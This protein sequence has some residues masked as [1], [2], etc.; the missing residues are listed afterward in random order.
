[1]PFDA[2]SLL[3]AVREVNQ[4]VAGGR[5]DKIY[6]PE[7]DEVVLSIRLMR[8]GVKLLLSVGAGTPRM[9]FIE[10]GRENPA[11]PPM[12][13]M[14]LR[15]HLTGARIVS[16]SQP[17]HERMLELEIDTHDE[18]GF[19]ARK[20]LVLE[21][22]GR[23][24]NLILVGS[25]G[26]IIDCMRRMDFA[27]DAERSM[28]PGMFYRMPPKQNKL[29]VFDAAEDERRALIAQADRTAPMDKWLL[30]AFSGLSPLL[31]RELAYRCGGDHE[32]LDSCISALLESLANGETAPYMLTRGGAPFD[33]SCIAIGQYGS[34]AETERFGSFSELLDNFY[35]RRDRL[36]RQRRRGSELTH[37][38]KTLRDRTARKLA[39]QSE[40][41]SRADSREELKKQAELVTANIYRMKKGDRELRCEDYY[42]PDC[43]EIVIP[44]DV[45]KTPQQNAA[46]MYKEYNKLK[47]AKEH[48]TVLVAQGEAQ[49]DY[50]NSVMSELQC[51]ESEKDLADI[52]LELIASGYDR[53]AKAVKKERLRPQQPLRFV[54]DDGLEVLVGRSN[55]QNDELTTKLARRTDYWLH[56]QKVHGSHAILCCD[57]L[58][59]PQRSI[60]QAA[61]IAAYYSQGRDS[62]KLPVDYTMVRFV[63]KPSGALPGKVIYTDYRTIIIE[64]DENLAER[65]RVKK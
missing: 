16:I 51:A 42:E 43:P 34:A 30:S 64:S 8:G 28:M 46:A 45:L 2:V 40:E 38:V 21:L 6:Q 58:E 12:F 65:L 10:T 49:L 57:G 20:K 1:M 15:K 59:P 17:E 52:R 55:I 41:L 62:G 31:C 9:H 63:R 3:A 13:C 23:S 39:A 53:K 25:D 50:L 24:S 60:E 22:I 56:T 32:R 14:L 29:S 48:L 37:Y 54:T 4:T 26:R 47:S 27:G 44:L 11:A 18:L 19:A 5:I 61:C 35:A 36:E 33:Y 7:R